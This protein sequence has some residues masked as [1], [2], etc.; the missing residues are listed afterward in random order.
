MPFLLGKRLRSDNH[1]HNAV[2][3]HTVSAAAA[4]GGGFKA[5]PARPNFGQVWSFAAAA[6]SDMVVLQHSK[7]RF[8][9]DFFNS[10]PWGR[11]GGVGDSAARV[12]N[13]PPIAQGHLNLLASLTGAPLQSS[14]RREDDS[15]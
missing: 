13:Y 9:R 2:N 4:A 15:R 8:P 1:D 7:L 14:G 3:K 5:I 6:S 12:G 10:N 11:A